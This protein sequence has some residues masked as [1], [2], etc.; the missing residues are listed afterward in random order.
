MLAQGKFLNDKEVLR[1]AAVRAGVQRPEECID[2]P[3]CCAQQARSSP[4]RC[5]S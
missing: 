2:D 1:E 3:E 4:K 5:S